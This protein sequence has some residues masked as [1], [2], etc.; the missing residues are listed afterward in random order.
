MLNVEIKVHNKVIAIVLAVAILLTMIPLGKYGPAFA[1][2]ENEYVLSFVDESG[3]A[4]SGVDL[5]YKII[6]DDNFDSPV[7]SESITVTGSEHSID[8]TEYKS[9]IEAPGT[10]VKLV[11]TASKKADDLLT[12]GIIDLKTTSG[13]SVVMKKAVKLTFLSLG[14]DGTLTVDGKAVTGEESYEKGTQV[15][16]KVAAPSTYKIHELKINGEKKDTAAEQQEF[17]IGASDDKLTLN[18]DTTIAVVFCNSE[19]NPDM[20]EFSVESVP[21]GGKLTASSVYDPEAFKKDFDSASTDS[22]FSVYK[23]DSVKIT[24][25][26]DSGYRIGEFIAGSTQELDKNNSYILSDPAE[27]ISVTFVKTELLTV[28]YNSAGGSVTVAKEDGSEIEGTIAGDVTSYTLDNPTEVIVTPTVSDG[29][30]LAKITVN[31]EDKS[32]TEGSLTITVDKTTEVA[33]EFVKLAVFTVEYDNEQGTVAIGIPDGAYKIDN[34]YDTVNG[35]YTVTVDDGTEITLTVSANT[36]GESKFRIGSVTIGGKAQTL[37]TDGT[38]S[39]KVSG[40]VEAAVSFVPITGLSVNNNSEQGQVSVAL[41]DDGTVLKGIAAGNTTSYVLDVPTDVNVSVKANEGYRIGAVSVNGEERQLTDGKLALTV[42]SAVEITVTY[43]KLASFSVSYDNTQGSVELSVPDGAY[44]S[45]GKYNAENHI[46]TIIVDDGTVVT[47]AVTPKND[48]ENA[49]YRIGMVLVGEVEQTLDQNSSFT[50]KAAGT[51]NASVTFVPLTGLSLIYD[52]DQGSVVVSAKDGTP[53]IGSVSGNTTSFTLDNP[54][55]AVISVKANAGYRIGS[56]TVNDKPQ[57]LTNGSFDYTVNNSTTVIVTFVKLA[58]LSVQ[59]ES[60]QGSVKLTVPDG[61]YVE[62]KGYDPASKT[63]HITVDDGTDVVI[64]VSANNTVGAADRYR[65]GKVTA[66][67]N[68]L[69]LDEH[70]SLTYGVTGNVTAK[71]EFVKLADINITYDN[72]FGTVELQ[73]DDPVLASSSSGQTYTSTYDDGTIVNILIDTN[74][75]YRIGSVKIDGKDVYEFSGEPKYQYTS[76]DDLHVTLTN[77]VVN[78]EIKFVKV[79][80]V[81]ISQNADGGSVDVSGINLDGTIDEEISENDKTPVTVKTKEGYYIREITASVK[82]VQIFKEKAE[83]DLVD[84]K[85]V[86]TEV[87]FDIDNINGDVEIDVEYGYLI[88]FEYDALSGTVFYENTNVGQNVAVVYIGDEKYIRISPSEGKSISNVTINGENITDYEQNSDETYDDVE[89]GSIFFRVSADKNLKIAAM[90]IDKI[91]VTAVDKVYTSNIDS[92]PF[93]KDK[94][95]Y[96]AGG[97]LNIAGAVS[98]TAVRVT[99]TVGGEEQVYGGT[100]FGY[101]NIGENIEISRIEVFYKAAGELVASWHDVS[102]FPAKQVLF[103]VTQP[104]LSVSAVN[105]SN[106]NSLYMEDVSVKISDIKDVDTSSGIKTIE[107]I[108]YGEDGKELPD[109]RKTLFSYDGGDLAYKLDD[110]TVTEG[111]N[112]PIRIEVK[113]TDNVGNT[114]SK[115]LDLHIDKTKPEISVEYYDD[116]DVKIPVSDNCFGERKAVITIKERNFD[117]AQ[118][119][120]AEIIKIAVAGFDGTAL[121]DKSGEKIDEYTYSFSE[122]KSG[123]NNNGTDSDTYSVSVYFAYDGN[124]TLTAN[125]TDLAGNVADTLTSDF[126]VDNTAPEGTVILRHSVQSGNGDSEFVDDDYKWENSKVGDADRPLDYKIYRNTDITVRV[127]GLYDSTSDI[128]TEYYVYYRSEGETAALT[129]EQLDKLTFTEEVPVISEEKEFVVYVRLTD[130]RAGNRKYLSTDGILTDYSNTKITLSRSDDDVDIYNAAYGDVKVTLSADDIYKDL[131]YSGIRTVS[132]KVI[133]DGNEE[134]TDEKTWNVFDENGR[135]GT[136]SETITIDKTKNNSNNVRVVVTVV[137]NAGNEITNDISLCIDITVPLLQLE[138]Q[139]ENR[140]NTVDGMEYYAPNDDVTVTITERDINFD[141]EK[142]KYT[143]TY[144]SDNSEQTGEYYT[145]TWDDDPAANANKDSDKHT[146]HI[147]FPRDGIYTLTVDYTDNAGNAAEQQKTVFTVDDTAPTGSITIESDFWSNLLSVLTFGLYSNTDKT[148]VF[149]SDDITAGVDKVEYYKEITPS[150]PS[151]GRTLAESLDILY[152]EGS[153]KQADS[154]TVSTD[155]V[156]TV[157]VRITDKAGNYTYISSDGYIVDKTRPTITM[158]ADSSAV[159]SNGIYNMLNGNKMTVNVTAFDPNTGRTG[160]TAYSGLKEITWRILNNGNVTQQGTELFQP[161]TSDTEFAELITRRDF[162]ISVDTS[163]N[164]SSNVTVEVTAS[165]NAGNVFTN[166]LELDIDITRPVI[167]VS[168]DNN[169]AVN[170]KY[171]DAVRTATVVITERTGHFRASEA[172]SG[173]RIR[174]VNALGSTINNAYSISGWKTTNNSNPDYS[175]HTATISFRRDANYTFAVSYS[176]MAGNSNSGVETGSSVAP[177]E[178]TVDTTAPTG[179]ISAVSAEG[180]Q[181][182]W[183]SLVRSLSFGF[184]S[185]RSIRI[186]DTTNDVTSPVASVDYYKVSA[187]N[188]AD[189]VTALTKE[190]LDGVNSWVKFSQLNITDDEQFTVYL[191]ITDMAG[192]YKYIST[193]G[194][195]VDENAPVTES[196]APII[197]IRQPKPEKGIYDGDV[198]MEVTVVDPTV[199]GTYSGINSIVYRVYDLAQNSSVPTATG[200]LYTF[201]YLNNPTQSQLSPE[202]TDRFTVSRS[203]NSNNVVVE[204]EARDNAG[205]ISVEETS[206]KI[207]TTAPVIN[208]SYNNNNP[209]SSIYFNADR[210]AT[211]AI[212]ERNFDSDDVKLTVK[213]DGAE[214]TPA[215]SGWRKTEGTGNEDNTV[216]TADLTYSQDGDY[217]FAIEYTDLAGNKASAPVYASGTAAPDS[218]TLDKTDPVVTVSYDNNSSENSNYFKNERTAT[219]TVVEHN[220]EASGIVPAITAS[221]NGQSTPSAIP[222]LSSWNNNGDIHTATLYY[223]AD[224]LY[225]FG[226]TA[227]DMAGNAS[228]RFANQSFYVDKTQ[229]SIEILEVKDKSANG[230]KDVVVAP[231]VR[232][233]DTNF[234]LSRVSITLTGAKN[235]SII[236]Y[237]GTDDKTDAEK[238]GTFTDIENGLQYVINNLTDDDIYTLSVTLTDMAGNV[239]SKQIEFSVNRLGSTFG[240]DQ[241]TLNVRDTADGNANLQKLDNDIV[242]YEVNPDELEDIEISI[243]KNGKT[244]VLEKDTDY[245]IDTETPGNGVEWYRYTYTIFRSVFADDATYD[246]IITSTDKAKNK[247]KSDDGITESGDKSNLSFTVDK[248]PPEIILTSELES[249]QTYA[250]DGMTVTFRAQDGTSLQSV[251]VELDGKVIQT[252]DSGFDE[253]LSFYISGESDAPHEVK[254]YC[255]DKAGNTSEILEVSDFWVTTNLLVRYYN[256]KPLFFGSIAGVVVLAGL[257]VFFVVWRRRK[258]DKDTQERQ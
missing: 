158:S 205:N 234:D 174:A 242:I 227:T 30:R 185:N 66:N 239:S 51:V 110:I 191:K 208:I 2:A 173:I 9:D 44:I 25:I 14:G 196:V 72:T 26:P 204:I 121:K 103:D 78:V 7:K 220:F 230:G 137:D 5:S 258:K 126:V 206:L 144:E 170:G 213:R 39:Y 11:Y 109:T 232:I 127:D 175:T 256:N 4:V 58:T 50:C 210:V 96:F 54:T 130:V 128:K 8:L 145:L 201:D 179:T 257:A 147:K 189:G 86:K 152:E 172:S 53:F 33:V 186:T 229:P 182:S 28:K 89:S 24:V 163:L 97:E 155:E 35:S 193:N 79:Y 63:H 107:Y 160:T 197:T 90:F 17:E 199:G 60:T 214:I 162:K 94:V 98:G 13:S 209:R 3:A 42:D 71:V 240:F 123:E 47:A 180:R 122:W 225:T 10:S 146:A 254:L 134:P 250:L 67:D 212:T 55:D 118:T 241:N 168:Y 77:N 164:N 32:L 221:D 105:K 169:N 184:W 237:S 249:G 22:K 100:A 187:K 75:G 34:G 74:D 82:G 253:E 222:V 223:S 81:E 166:E 150:L 131:P 195:I 138:H 167:S 207:D 153:F 111:T 92:A 135:Q 38:V 37:G 200:T 154:V 116:K 115:F 188:A 251:T 48:G 203:N 61:A 245:K 76:D 106:D 101:I 57:E 99:G 104:D 165:D 192:N 93:N 156:F 228:E 125:Y 198:E 252:W 159:S 140:T 16:I 21:V 41:A 233:N 29:Y 177:Y 59:Y 80:N 49:R 84:R 226:L 224:A 120:P 114:Y 15:Q 218:F 119:D 95:Y 70:G 143:V 149:A 248:T 27:K 6:K 85:D 64:S 108:I 151:S 238:H 216:W 31:G 46:H 23:N 73:S 83:N 219:I 255:I 194:L 124:Y 18:S 56:V 19:G 142:L 69:A 43:V 176:D 148:A 247:K 211:V 202:E 161:G 113:I 178:F 139:S 171:F 91:K 65:I 157:Y 133:A 136:F 132:Y 1:E 87:T 88:E 244:I 112:L 52:S 246:I 181:E 217:T 36:S 62:D 129:V 235:K 20:T 40:N 236:E 68:E 141:R 190:Q 215:L 117:P 231:V 102:D 12:T 45:D 183:S 243:R